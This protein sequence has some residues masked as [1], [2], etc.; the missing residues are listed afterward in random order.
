MKGGAHQRWKAHQ[1][2][3]PQNEGDA[4]SEEEMV[5]EGDG[6]DMKGEKWRR[7]MKKTVSVRNEKE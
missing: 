5:R 2:K 7:R 4:Y 6:L 3:H 1:G